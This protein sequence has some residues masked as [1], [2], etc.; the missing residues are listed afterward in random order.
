MEWVGGKLVLGPSFG[1]GG[2]A[3]VSGLRLSGLR[4]QPDESRRWRTSIVDALKGPTRA[5]QF[6]DRAHKL[7]L[8]PTMSLKILL[9]GAGGRE[10]ALA[11][12]LSRSD[13]VEHI[14]ICPG[15]GGTLTANKCSNLDVISLTDFP[16]LVAFALKNDVRSVP[17]ISPPFLAST[18]PVTGQPRCSWS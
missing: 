18:L 9:L 15:N 7:F 17:F 2:G 3:S 12:R 16:G 6:P 11:W 13:L 1:A 8:S 14:Y 4:I 10:H 5:H